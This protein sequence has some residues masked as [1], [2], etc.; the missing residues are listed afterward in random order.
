M[1]SEKQIDITIVIPA[2]NEAENIAP[3]SA[4]LVE[5]MRGINKTYEVIIVDDGSKDA[6]YDEIL[7]ASKIH[8]QIRGLK[9][10]KN[11]G[12]TAAFNAG[13]EYALGRIVITM[14]AD[15][16]NDPADIP[17]LLEKM[18]EF[19]VVCGI[20]VKRQDNFVR[21]ASSKIANFIRNLLTKDTIIDTGCS[22]KAFK[23]EAAKRMKLFSGMHRFF[24]TL[25]KMDGYTVAQVPV[26]H[27]PRKFGKAK[28]GV[29]N[30]AFRAFCDLMAVRWMQKRHFKYEIENGIQNT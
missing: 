11:C 21:R 26:N 8:P 5:A 30:R 1:N 9:F 28:Y 25:A 4:S 22:L 3:L 15:M 27:L 13:F 16:Q 18:P 2:Y 12:Q 10:K 19:D 6:T 24:P 20:R 29:G 23:A 14:D 7:K 17:K